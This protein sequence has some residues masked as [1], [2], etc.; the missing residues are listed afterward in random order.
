MNSEFQ[1][2]QDARPKTQDA[3]GFSMTEVLI[4]VGI[5]AVGMLFIAGV[6]PVS[7]HFT[8]VSFERTIAATV[9]EEA[10]AK[11]EL[12]GIPPAVLSAMSGVSQT[13]IE[14]VSPVPFAEFAYPSIPT[15]DPNSRRYW[16]SAICRRVGPADVQVT[17]FVS[18]KVGVASEYWTRDRLSPLILGRVGHPEPLPVHV[19]A[20]VMLRPDQLR[21]N[22]TLGLLNFINDGYTIVD[23]ETGNLYRVLQR[24]D[25]VIQLDKSWVVSVPNWIWTIPA[26]ISSSPSGTTGRYPCIAAYQKVMRF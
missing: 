6:F 16:W 2:T 13:P 15:T 22:D 11:I 9:A 17:V 14:S 7:I 1:K 4:A 19:E 10:F 18:R 21:I 23:D 20:D 26:S 25:N 12:Y 3:N 8:T 24:T 5:L